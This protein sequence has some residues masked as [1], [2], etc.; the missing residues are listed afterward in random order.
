MR[1]LDQE[2][3]RVLET[4]RAIRYSVRPQ[5]SRLRSNRV[6]LP[7]LV[8][9]GSSTP[10]HPRRTARRA[11]SRRVAEGYAPSM[12]TRRPCASFAGPDAGGRSVRCCAQLCASKCG[13]RILRTRSREQRQ[14][15]LGLAPMLAR[16]RV[17]LRC[18]RGHGRSLSRTRWP[19][20]PLQRVKIPSDD[21][22]GEGPELRDK[23][24]RRTDWIAERSLR[25]WSPPRWDQLA[26]QTCVKPERE[27][28]QLKIAKLATKKG[29]TGA[30]QRGPALAHRSGGPAQPLLFTASFD[31]D[32]AGRFVASSPP[33][34][35]GLSCRSP[36]L[37]T[38]TSV[39]RVRPK[40]SSRA[41][42]RSAAKYIQRRR[43]IGALP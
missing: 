28:D 33:A 39:N 3:H 30:L 32:V 19:S 27:H 6:A 37:S 8:P 42:K 10:G 15:W 7:H 9:T 5:T 2:S 17:G 4:P 34:L 38:S 13:G 12:G 20:A 26:P 35:I 43:A 16:W 40:A 25:R 22:V 11:Q 24:V 29:S 31:A 14:V 23:P 1:Y 36:P 18:W 21:G 41:T